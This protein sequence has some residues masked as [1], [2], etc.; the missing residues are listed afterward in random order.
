V[1]EEKGGISEDS[2]AFYFLFSYL[3][4]TWELL[5]IMCLGLHAERGQALICGR[6][7]FRRIPCLPEG[8]QDWGSALCDVVSTAFSNMSISTFTVY[9]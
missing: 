3:Q 6:N 8:M 7:T 4:K 9:F 5:L 1:L 2:D